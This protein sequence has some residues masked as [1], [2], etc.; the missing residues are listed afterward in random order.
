MDDLGHRV[1]M[2]LLR[3]GKGKEY[4]GTDAVSRWYDRNLRIATHIARLAERPGERILVIIGSGHC[5]L[6][7]QFI[8]EMPGFELVD[9]LNY[10]K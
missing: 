4:P 3:V 1:Y 5:K 7:R 2:G 8:R 10:L 9:C 6:L